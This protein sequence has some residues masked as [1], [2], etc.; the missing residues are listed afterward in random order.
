MISRRLNPFHKFSNLFG[1]Q[2]RRIGKNHEIAPDE[3]FIDSSNLPE[4]DTDQFE[5]QIE[6]PISRRSLQIAGFLFVCVALFF[7][8]KIANLQ[9]VSGDKFRGISENNRLHHSLI[10]AERGAIL[11]REGKILAWNEIDPT[12]AEFS[13]RQYAAD[14]GIHNLLG[15]VKYPKKDKFGFYYNTEYAGA[16]GVEKFF[17]E[18][19]TGTNGLKITE[20]D[21]LGK[22]LSE[23][24]VRPAKKGEN[25]SLSIHAGAQKAMYDSIAEIARRSGFNGGAAVVMD[26]TTGEVLTSVSFPEYDSNVLTDGKDKQRISS[27]LTNPNN[28]FLD[29]V[30]SGLYTPG[31]I[32]KP[33][34]AFAAL[35]EGVITPEKQIESTGELRVPNPYRPGEYTVFKDWKAHGFTDMR[36][37]IAVSSDVYFYQVGGGF[38]GQKGLG[39]DNIGKYSHLFGFGDT[40][41]G[42]FFASKKGVIPN[43]EWKK[44]NFNGDIWRVGDTYNTAIGQYGFQ[45][46]PIQAVRAVAVLANGGT[47]LTPTIISQKSSVEFDS[48]GPTRKEIL[49]NQSGADQWYKVVREGMRDAVTEGTMG[50]VNLPYVK[51]A[52]KTGTAQLGISKKYI[53]SWA[54]GFFPYEKPRYA[55]AILLEKG[56]NDATVGATAA[57]ALWLEWMN[58]Y[59]NDY[60]Q[61]K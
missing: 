29:R 2:G 54:T 19:L 40:M 4:F 28:P 58:I 10:F 55:F 42:T 51:V 7:T 36:R 48:A 1:G 5:G 56:P 37:A 26:V 31:S 47:L 17:N 16:D 50:G 34:L 39:I 44:L 25:V 59:A 13:L 57:L 6:K 9:V 53:N 46:T 43:P 23:S 3:I 27:Y 11:D 18:T 33:I 8:Y 45:I 14:S 20:T 30:S 41:D 24:T 52:G 32:V 60:L 12:Q 49:T 61:A 38:P 22:T 35:A 21:A 15:Y